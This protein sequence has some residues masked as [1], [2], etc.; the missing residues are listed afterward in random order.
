MLEFPYIGTGV[1]SAP[2]EVGS[3]LLLTEAHFNERVAESKGRAGGLPKNPCQRAGYLE[4][5]AGYQQRGA[6]SVNMKRTNG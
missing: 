2:H 5:D 6:G 3:R 4:R 1:D